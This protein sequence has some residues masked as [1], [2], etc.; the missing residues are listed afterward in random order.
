MLLQ[1]QGILDDAVYVKWNILFVDFF[2]FFSAQNHA[3]EKIWYETIPLIGDVGDTILQAANDN[4]CLVRKKK[5][6]K[7]TTFW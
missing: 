3:L 2:C 7:L 6:E 4:K 5:K 1:A